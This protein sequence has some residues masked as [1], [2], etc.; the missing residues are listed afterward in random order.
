[1]SELPTQE[2][3]VERIRER[4]DHDVLH[5]EIQYYFEYI[6]HEQAKLWLKPDSKAENWDEP[7]TLDREAIIADM[8]GYMPFAFGKAHGQRGISATRSIY[9]YIAWTW[10]IGD[11]EFSKEIQDDANY[12]PYG[13]TA[14]RMIC[15]KYGFK[16]EEE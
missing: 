7:K 11:T 14:L 8:R 10:L 2:Q 6:T 16:E 3:I 9:H 1:M 13:L 5:F 12:A 4:I 15:E